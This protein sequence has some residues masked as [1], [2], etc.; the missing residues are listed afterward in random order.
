MRMYDFLPVSTDHDSL[1]IIMRKGKTFVIN[2]A[3]GEVM[4][5]GENENPY[6]LI[7]AEKF[8]SF[9]RTFSF[10]EDAMIE[11]GEI[12]GAEYIEI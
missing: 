9:E 1:F 11:I 6:D 2:L 3:N 8:G 5:T 7:S 4:E 12:M 10:P